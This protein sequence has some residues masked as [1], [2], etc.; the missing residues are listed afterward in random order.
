V[1]GTAQSCNWSITPGLAT[2]A[3]RIRVIAT[4]NGT[5]AN[6]QDDSNANFTILH[7]VPLVTRQYR[8]DKLSRL[9]EITRE[10]N[11]KIHY[12]YDNVGN[13]LTLADE[14]TDTDGDGVP[15]YSDNCPTVPNPSQEDTDADGVGNACDNCPT[16]SNTNQAD[17]DLDSVGN[18]CDNCRNNCNSQQ[19]DADHDGIG[20]VCDP[21]PGCGGCGQPA[22]E[23]QCL[24]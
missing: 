23:Q 2:T 18:V 16:V 7:T 24:I 1:P 11:G 14:V 4:E 6:I 10:D 8:Y 13:L 21:S 9:K 3:A 17:S 20:D 12:I 22:C 5:G 19:L 15:D